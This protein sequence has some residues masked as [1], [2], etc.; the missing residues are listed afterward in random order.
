MAKRTTRAQVAQETLRIHERGDYLSPTGRHVSIRDALASA[1]A[2]SILYTPDHFGEVS[3]RGDR[4]LRDA[5]ARPAVS[6]E[7]VNETTLHVARR[8]VR[9]GGR[10]VL[11]LNFASA[12]H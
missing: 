1:Q 6:I 2:R 5:G 7:V 3:A 12:R 4:L 8:L 11:A 10:S 9:E